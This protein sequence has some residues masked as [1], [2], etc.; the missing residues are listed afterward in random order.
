MNDKKREI[1]AAGRAPKDKILEELIT[2]VMYVNITITPPTYTNTMTVKS[3]VFLV[4]NT[5]AAVTLIVNKPS[6]PKNGEV[7][8]IIDNKTSVY[9]SN[10]IYLS[11]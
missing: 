11:I 6:I 10:Q 2:L 9:S 1:V 3:Q 8:K 5:K 7:E 4:P